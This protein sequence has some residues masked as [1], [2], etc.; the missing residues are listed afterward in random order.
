MYD[1]GSKCIIVYIFECK[2]MLKFV[3]FIIIT[4]YDFYAK[5]QLKI[6]IQM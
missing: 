2:F 3:Q 1:K 5:L 6:D 4:S